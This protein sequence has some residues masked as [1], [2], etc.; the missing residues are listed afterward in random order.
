[1]DTARRLR[2]ERLRTLLRP[3]P[4]VGV[5]LW[6]RAVVWLAAIWALVWFEPKPPPLQ[7]LWDVPQ[8]HDL[9]YGID[10]WAHWDSG[11][12]LA[13]AEHGYASNAGTAAFY[14][15]YPGLVAVLGRILGDHFLLAGLLV[16]LAACLASFVLLHRLAASRLGAEGARRAV[17][18]LALFPMS[19]FLQA[20]YSESLFLALA[21]ATFL[22]AERNR[23]AWA[24]V[25]CGLALLTRPIGVALVLALV[26]L[27]WRSGDR[28]RNLSRLG[29]VPLLFAAF[30]IGLQWQV[31]DW[32]AF[33]HVESVWHRSVSPAG[34]FGGIWDGLRAGWDGV[35][36]LAAGPGST[37]VYWPAE[38]SDPLHVASVN[39]EAVGFLVV[40]LWLTWL[41]WRR[42]GTAYGLFAAASLAIPLSMPSAT[43]PL[44]SLPRFGVVV[45]PFFLA[46]ATV[47]EQ[48]RRHAAILGA[49][50]AFLGVAVVQWAL[51]QWVS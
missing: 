1:V 37:H 26:W 46:L 4:A 11:W 24:S 47:G 44:L 5:F 36:Q 31:H 20:V 18:Y 45:F 3:G 9:G 25:A 32:S 17:V 21:L 14:P 30:P 50:G 43:Y 49:S 41:A 15:L 42:L 39:V 13:I 7:E 35:R 19:L 51:W 2:D 38:G 16:S 33:L 29:L 8:L 27:A 10:V 40:F 48:P 12:F 22:L 23:F 28:L 34:P 6:S